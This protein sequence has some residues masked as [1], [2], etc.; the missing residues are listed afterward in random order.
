[1]AN[2]IYYIYCEDANY[3]HAESIH[4]ADFASANSNGVIIF[5]QHAFKPLFERLDNETSGALTRSLI[6][7]IAMR[8]KLMNVKAFCK[9]VKLYNESSHHPRPTYITQIAFFAKILY[10]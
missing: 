5:S 6:W 10:I 2:I 8:S 3:I 9:N 1:M 7:S 4:A